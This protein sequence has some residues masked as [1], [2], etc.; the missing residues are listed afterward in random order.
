MEE[1]PLSECNSVLLIHVINPACWGRFFTESKRSCF[2]STWI[3]GTLWHSLSGAASALCFGFILWSPAATKEGAFIWVQQ[4]GD[5]DNLPSLPEGCFGNVSEGY[6]SCLCP[7]PALE[8][9]NYYQIIEGC[10]CQILNDSHAAE[11]LCYKSDTYL[12]KVSR[13]KLETLVIFKIYVGE[14]GKKI[15]VIQQIFIYFLAEQR[16]QTLYMGPDKSL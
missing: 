8:K 13:Q 3:K 14:E 9:P 12:C 6:I 15:S 10:F 7:Q 4:H 1:A 11:Q 16:T 5:L 2:W